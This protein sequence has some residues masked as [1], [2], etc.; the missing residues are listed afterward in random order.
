[1]D[2]PS[3]QQTKKE[4]GTVV[5]PSQCMMHKDGHIW[6]MGDNYTGF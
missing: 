4:L 3:V 5:P 2:D 1:M 6:N